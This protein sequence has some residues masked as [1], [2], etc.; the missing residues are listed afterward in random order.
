MGKSVHADVQDAAANTI[1]NNATHLCVCS[2][3]PATRAEAYETYC[4]AKTNISS[5]SFTLTSETG[6]RVLT[7]SAQPA[8]SIATSGIM[9]HYAIIDS[10][11]LLMV[12]TT[13]SQTLVAGNQVNIPSI[14]MQFSNPV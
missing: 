13:T 12:T 3:Q 7:A 4:L 10:T 5:G 1:R 11:R 2:Q 6:G 14:A 9:T 8:V